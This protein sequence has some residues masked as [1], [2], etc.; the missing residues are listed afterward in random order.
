MRS[1]TLLSVAVACIAL[2]S[3]I[4]TA[5]PAMVD[6][7][8]KDFSADDL[9]CRVDIFNESDFAK[10]SAASTVT[11]YYSDKVLDSDEY[12]ELCDALTANP[13]VTRLRNAIKADP[14]VSKWFTDNDINPDSAI[15][16][17][18]QGD[19]KFDLYLQ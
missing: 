18:N 19:G 9:T 2:Y 11:V 16:M 5:Q 10:F 13:A 12:E 3:P 4:A 6:G 7:G 14:D 1:K 8:S 15:L 17:V